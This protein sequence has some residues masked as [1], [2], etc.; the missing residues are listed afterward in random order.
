MPEEDTDRVEGV[1]FTDTSPIL[2]DVSY[3]ITAD[4]LIEQHGD[5]EVKRTNAEPITIQELF[6]PIG[7]TTFESPSD[8]RQMILNLMPE[9]SVGREGY[10][11]RGGSQPEEGGETDQPDESESV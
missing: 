6:N 5:H 9:E 7:D 10:S 8:V 11:D 2:E 3:P 4:E 1:D